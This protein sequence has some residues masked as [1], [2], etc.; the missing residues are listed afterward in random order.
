MDW[1]LAC[2]SRGALL[3]WRT[4]ASLC[5]AAIVPAH[6]PVRTH[7]CC[8]RY[9]KTFD[10]AG[11]ACSIQ[12]PQA[13]H[14]CDLATSNNPMVGGYDVSITSSKGA[15][16]KTIHL[17]SRLPKP[18]PND[19][20]AYAVHFSLGKNEF[21]QDKGY[22]VLSLLTAQHSCCLSFAEACS[23][24]WHGI[25][26]DLS[27]LYRYGLYSQG[28][29]SYGLCSYGLYS[30]GI[31]GALS[32]ATCVQPQCELPQ[33]RT[34]ARQLVHC[35]HMCGIVRSPDTHSSDTAMPIQIRGPIDTSMAGTRTRYS[36]P[37]LLLRL[38]A[39]QHTRHHRLL[40]PTAG[41]VALRTKATWLQPTVAKSA[42]AGTAETATS[43]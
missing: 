25:L 33:W 22:Q 41:H 28:L 10:S 30:Y 38:S 37:A 27:G 8:H 9:A 35:A 19:V 20:W 16:S 5:G 42:K 24:L 39:P 15:Q 43:I 40:R 32:T 18:Y 29:Y 14:I 7:A 3:H 36:L 13:M 11:I 34:Q 12:G 6:M 21:G 26:G 1:M 4:A 17:N 31:P 2:A 23:F